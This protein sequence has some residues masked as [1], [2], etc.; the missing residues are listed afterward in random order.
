MDTKKIVIAVASVVT[1]LLLG[2]VVY[3]C[4]FR[5]A[6]THLEILGNSKVGQKV[7]KLFESAC[8]N[9]SVNPKNFPTVMWPTDPE[10]PAMVA[11]EVEK[12]HPIAAPLMN[13]LTKWTLQYT[14]K[15]KPPT[16]AEAKELR[17]YAS[18]LDA[19]T[20]ILTTIEKLEKSV[21]DF[22][23]KKRLTNESLKE[24]VTLV[25]L[26]DGEKPPASLKTMLSAVK[27]AASELLVAYPEGLN[28]IE[29][30]GFVMACIT[31]YMP[32]AAAH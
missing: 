20:E 13:V 14:D 25:D 18:R 31:P 12:M 5:R 32:I 24:I 30:M 17:E 21:K 22:E 16:E 10:E 6:P 2:V 28:K 29:I 11:L 26:F 8:L 1:A 27:T 7:A 23:V 19:K 3:S 9:V 15:N 4:C